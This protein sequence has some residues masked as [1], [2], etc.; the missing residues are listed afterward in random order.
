MEEEESHEEEVF[1]LPQGEEPNPEEVWGI[2]EAIGV[3]DKDKVMMDEACTSHEFYVT[4]SP[5]FEE[6]LSKEPFAVSLFQT[7]ATPL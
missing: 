2:E 3:Q 4:S 6:L 7:K 1:D 5:D